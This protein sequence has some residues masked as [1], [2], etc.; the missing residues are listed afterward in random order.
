MKNV[1]RLAAGDFRRLFSNIVS[2]IIVLGLVL[3]PSIFTWYNVL[4]CWDVF[5]NTGNLKVAVAN[6]DEGYQS[7]LVPLKVNIGDQVLAAL[8]ENDQMNWVFTD[9]E[10]AVDGAEAGRYYAAVVI[11]PSFSRDMM[12]FY[13]G[14]VEHA[15][16]VYYANEKKNA[17][18]PKVTGQGADQISAQV[19]RVFAETLS[20]AALGISSA[21][22]AYMDDADAAGALGSL[23]GA[24]GDAG[25]QMTAAADALRLHARVLGSARALIEGSGGLLEQAG[26][27]AGEAA[28]AADEARGAAGSAADAMAG[29]SEALS[30]ALEQSAAG[31]ASVPAALDAAFDSASRVAA[32]AASQLRGASSA[33]QGQGAALRDA[34]AQLQEAAGAVPQE[35][36]P[37]LEALAGQLDASADLADQLGSS[38]STAAD[39]VEAGDAD[40]QAKREEAALLAQQAR[41]SLEGVRADYAADVAPVLERLADEAGSIASTLPAMA[42]ALQSAG[43]DL[44]QAAGSAAQRLGA[45]QD[46]LSSAADELAASGA[47]LSELSQRL[48]DALAS[49]DS[50]ALRQAIGQDPAALAQALSAP[51]QL[52][53]QAV[54][55]VASFGSAM[56]PLYTALALWI[57][58]LLIM[59]A[60]KVAPC[61]RALAQLQDPAPWQLFAGRFVVVAALSLLQS[62]CIGLGN[63]LFLGIQ[64]VE[65]VLYLV[66]LWASGLVF[67]FI[68]YTLV[69]SFANFGKALSVMLLI[70][71]VSGGG[72]SF[73]LALLPG[74]FQA[75]G[76][77]LPVTHAVNAMRAAM[78]GVYQGDFWV[79]MGVLA[80]FA[81]PFVLLGFVVRNPLIKVV[82]RFVEKVE[83]TKVM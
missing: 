2:T 70:L 7:D 11:P 10:D 32:D 26:T 65:P 45:A 73:P 80:L 6:S 21:L 82:D 54:Y 61:D 68:V 14:E 59:V 77:A 5:G 69:A 16:I 78:F 52:D 36:R 40:A 34:A 25:G 9:E 27:L 17:I 48:A 19:N 51:V 8:R 13:S 31:F 50:Q 41:D 67:S 29:A 3:L 46:A 24:I 55:P 53:R 56:A 49:G 44:S 60:L 12:T 43:G 42:A 76:P 71:Q 15:R 64:A 38:L 74:F 39:A 57:G 37:A 81:V 79:E 4:A 22:L 23:A 20:E 18:A 58:A 33:A 75:V 47:E 35:S 66:S 72:G 62:T 63:L 28:G 30:A 1:L 83:S